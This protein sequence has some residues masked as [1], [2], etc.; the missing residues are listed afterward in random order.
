MLDPRL[1]DL[2]ESGVPVF[3]AS[4]LTVPVHLE[5][6]A[7]GLGLEKKKNVLVHTVYGIN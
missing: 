1:A 4:K 5:L 2:G 6:F 7:A 3:R